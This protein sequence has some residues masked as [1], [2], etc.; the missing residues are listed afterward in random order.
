[1][2]L[3]YGLHHVKSLLTVTDDVLTRRAD[4]YPEPGK[5]PLSSTTPTIIEHSDG[6]LHLVV[7]AS[8]GSRIFGSVFQ[9][10]LNVNWSMDMGHAIGYGRL[11]DQLY[12]STLNVEEAFPLD[13]RED[14]RARG[15][16]ITSWSFWHPPSLLIDN[17]LLATEFISSKVQGI[18]VADGYIYGGVF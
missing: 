17:I 18:A 2:G 15:H 12:P 3:G 11:H 4:N 1:M 16:N 8:G 14:L 7:G 9:A 6:S 10:I 13:L 5:R